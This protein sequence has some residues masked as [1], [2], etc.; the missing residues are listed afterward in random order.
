VKPILVMS[1]K[2][3]VGKTTVAANLAA[4]LKSFGFSVGFLDA[5]LYGP[6]A[7]ILLGTPEGVPEED[8][9]SRKIKPAKT[10]HG[11]EFMSIAVANIL[12]RGV[13]L[14]IPAD[15]LRQAIATFVNH[16]KWSADYLVVDCP[17]GS[18]DINQS[19]LE[20]LAGRAGVVYVSQ[21]HPMS[22]EDMLRIIDVARIYNVQGLALVLNM[23]NLFPQ[24][25]RKMVY[26]E[27]VERV[28][29][30]NVIEIP[31]DPDL[32]EGVHP[33]KEYFIK[34]AKVVA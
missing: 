30:E 7:H 28:G 3:G 4:A 13:G 10:R 22:L 21:P 23:V 18:Y 26:S 15:K 32:V 9:E 27:L 31:W 2:G 33:T 29:I 11:I 34:L 20:L 12:P 1:G 6:V 17:P 24:K 5:D 14:N 25:Y 8:I 19:L 16:V